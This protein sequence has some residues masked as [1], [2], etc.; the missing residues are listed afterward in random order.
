MKRT[1]TSRRTKC[2][3]VLGTFIAPVFAQ[4]EFSL[5][6]EYRPRAEFRSGYS[7]PLSKALDP[8]LLM[9]QRVRLNT[10]YRSQFVNARLSIQDSRV[11]GEANQKGESV[12]KN[13]KAPTLFLYEAWT[14]L[15]LPKGVAFRIGRQALRYDDQRLISVN[16]WSNTGGAHDLALLTYRTGGFKADLG[17]AY[18]ND[19]A[20][21]LTSDYAYGPTSFYKNLAYLWLCHNFKDSGVKVAAIAVSEG[22]QEEKT[23]E[24]ESVEYINHYRYTYGGNIEFKK[25]DFPLSVYATAYGQSGNTNK[26]IDLSAYMLALKLNYEIIKPL[27]VSGGVDFYS[28][29]NMKTDPNKKTS[30]YMG[31]YGSNHGFNGAMDYWSGT[32]VPTGGLVDLYLSAQYKVNSKVTLLA[33]Y[34]SFRLAKE[35][36]GCWDKKGLGNEIDLDLTYKFCKFVTVNAGWSAYFKSDLTNIVKGVTG[37]TS[38]TKDT[39]TRFGQWAYVSLTITPQLFTYKK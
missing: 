25:A 24:D 11:F 23:N 37:V 9:M 35:M 7:Q 26:G 22:F 12:K 39:D 4:H 31:L 1:C 20:N 38:P 14:E 19:Q 5:D 6:A 10:D 29:T 2:L 34:H 8:D 16:N 21:P 30:T 27:T 18:K 28:G 13:G 36:Q 15:M 32:T 17:Y 33:S 3:L